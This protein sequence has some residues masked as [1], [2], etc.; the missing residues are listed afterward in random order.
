MTSG[1][2]SENKN[3]TYFL[4]G[5]IDSENDLVQTILEDAENNKKKHID[6]LRKLLAVR[7]LQGA[8]KTIHNRQNNDLHV[9][10]RIGS[11]LDENKE[12]LQRKYMIYKYEEEKN[13][14]RNRIIINIT[15]ILL[16]LIIVT[17]AYKYYLIGGRTLSALYILSSIVVGFYIAYQYYYDYYIRDKIFYAEMIKTLPKD[18]NNKTLNESCPNPY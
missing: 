18:K 1:M 10:D 13:Q 15:L 7:E 6:S 4:D 9:L 5:N 16:G 2:E 12:T 14:D 3:Y 8:H 11:E 17:V